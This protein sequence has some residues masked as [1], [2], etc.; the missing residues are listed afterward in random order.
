MKTLKNNE[1]NEIDEINEIKCTIFFY[2]CFSFII[3]LIYKRFVVVV[4][5][6]AIRDCQLD[7]P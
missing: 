5:A 7:Y 4:I 2:F 3:M 6:W 1:I